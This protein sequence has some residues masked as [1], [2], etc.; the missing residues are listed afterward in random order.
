MR[1]LLLTSLFTLIA[2]L[3]LAAPPTIAAQQPKLDV[4][5]YV[6]FGVNFDL[7]MFNF[8]LNYSIS[9]DSATTTSYRTGYH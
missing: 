9:L 5:V 4:K 6:G 1:K 8:D 3:H 2:L 7:A